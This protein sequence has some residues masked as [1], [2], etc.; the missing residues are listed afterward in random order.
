MTKLPVSCNG[1]MN[2]PPCLEGA[3]SGV[4]GGQPPAD[5]ENCCR[6]VTHI[7]QGWVIRNLRGEMILLVWGRHRSF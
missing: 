6:H 1:D 7:N 5:T 2:M 3:C 4:H